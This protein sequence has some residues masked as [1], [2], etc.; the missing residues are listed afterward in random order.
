MGIINAAARKSLSD[1][2]K[3]RDEFLMAAP[4]DEKPVVTCRPERRNG[5]TE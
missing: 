5:G 2:G 1:A 4:G 3:Y